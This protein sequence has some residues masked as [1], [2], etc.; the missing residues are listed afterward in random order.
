M[1]GHDGFNGTSVSMKGRYHEVG[2]IILEKAGCND[3]NFVRNASAKKC[4][5]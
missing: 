5:S 3:I 4:M 1:G 2:K